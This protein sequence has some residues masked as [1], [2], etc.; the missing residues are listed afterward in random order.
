MPSEPAWSKNISGNTVCSWFYF[1][2]VL[3]LLFGVA[4]LARVCFSMMGGKGSLVEL[5]FLMLFIGLGFMNSWF[6]FLVCNRGLHNEGFGK[7]MKMAGK[8][9]KIA[10]YSAL[11]VPSMAY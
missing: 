11:G 5:S 6:L 10:A 3:N 8:V 9:A 7:K 4:G 1:L 2:A